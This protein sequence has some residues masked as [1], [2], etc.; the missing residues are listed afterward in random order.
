MVGPSGAGKGSLIE[1]A[2]TML[3]DEPRLTF[4][5]RVITQRD[6]I[7]EDCLPVS[8]SEFL[9]LESAGAFALAWRAHG[10]AYGVSAGIEIALAAGRSVVVNVSRS[11]IDVARHRLAPV[12]VLQIKA[13]RE[14]LA[15]RLRARSRERRRYPDAAASRR[16]VHDRGR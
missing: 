11:L 10:L 3:A 1:A 5:R 7:G 14:L 4:P 8:T 12:R 2:R 9:R 16:G 15:A 13:A 6:A